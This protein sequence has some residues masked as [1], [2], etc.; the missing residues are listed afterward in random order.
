MEEGSEFQALV[1]RVQAG[2]AGAMAD[3]IETYDDALLRSA[4]KLVGKFLRSHLDALDL[5]QSVHL[6]LW[7]GLCEGKLTAANPKALLAL[8]KV[9]L[10]RVVARHWRAAKQQMT[11]SLDA[12]LFDTVVD[13][14]L[15]PACPQ[16]TPA[17]STELED[18]LRSF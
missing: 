13:R 7:R 5:V 1:G 16:P 10:R 8:A 6:I 4:E 11:S 3:L 15:M 17:K 9:V 18:L 14:P 12:K 2:D